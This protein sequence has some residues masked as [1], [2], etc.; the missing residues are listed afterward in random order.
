M[1]PRAF[2]QSGESELVKGGIHCA[3]GLIMAIMATYNIAA[4]C[5]RKEKHLAANAVLYTCLTAL[6][7][8]KTIDHWS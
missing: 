6:E 5:Y 7:A 3:A 2:V 4:L 8:R 1:T